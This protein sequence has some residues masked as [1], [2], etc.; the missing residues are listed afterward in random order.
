VTGSFEESNKIT[1]TLFCTHI[2]ARTGIYAHSA[3][4]IQLNSSNATKYVQRSATASKRKSSAHFIAMAE[5]VVHSAQIL[6][7]L[8]RHLVVSISNENTRTAPPE[9]SH[10]EKC[11]RANTREDLC[12]C[13]DPTSA[14]DPADESSDLAELVRGY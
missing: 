10:N 3:G 6:E 4:S 9:P 12:E 13:T 7:L 5:M 2:C 11:R 8:P 14:E 1:D